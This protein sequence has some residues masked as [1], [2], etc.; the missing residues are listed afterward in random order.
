MSRPLS[1]DTK[2]LVDS[3]IRKSGLTEFQKKTLMKEMRESGSLPTDVPPTTR[4]IPPPPREVHYTPLPHFQPKRSREAILKATDNYKPEQPLSGIGPDRDEESRRLA[5]AM[6]KKSG[7][8]PLIG[9]TSFV[10][11]DNPKEEAPQY[12]S[13]F[14]EV[15]NEIKERRE[16]L[17]DM[18]KLGKGKEME[19]IIDS[20]IS[21]LMIELESIH[22]SDVERITGKK[23]KKK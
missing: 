3:L 13:R 8:V 20:Q 5:T 9:H 6:E 22:K 1:S 10:K 2:T 12:E 16:F 21:E 19:P 14:E 18:R 7:Q 11:K 23:K 4:Y 17:E 15:L